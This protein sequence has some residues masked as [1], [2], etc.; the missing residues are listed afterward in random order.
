M[1]KIEEES[2]EVDTSKPA[3]PSAA[4]AAEPVAVVEKP[5]AAA[6]PP[7]QKRKYTKKPKATTE[8]VAATETAPAAAQSDDEEEEPSTKRVRIT[9]EEPPEIDQPS[10]FRGAFVQPLILGLLGAATFYAKNVFSTTAPP[11][12]AT[13][14]PAKKKIP[15]PVQTNF[16]KPSVQ[17]SNRGPVIQGFS[18]N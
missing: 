18:H 5:V 4:V 12:A 1:Q 8:T 9:K 6:A 14:P 3:E 7:K 2:A 16:R 10:L 11:A 17:F 13:A 15:L